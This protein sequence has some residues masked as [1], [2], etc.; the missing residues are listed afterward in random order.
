MPTLNIEGRKVRVGD[1][2]LSLSP[3]EQ[4]ATVEEI[5]ASFSEAPAGASEYVQPAP[6]PGMVMDPETGQ[7][8]DTAQREAVGR[9]IE[10]RT[11]GVGG[12]LMRTG[13]VA[14]DFVRGAADMAT[15]GTADEI[16]AALSGG[17]YEA[18][19]EA[20]RAQDDA[21]GAARF[22]GQMAGGLA[23][24]TMAARTLPAAIGQG[25]LMGGAYGFGS[26]EGG[27]AARA[28]NA[29]YGAAVGGAASG[30][31]Q[32]V[33]NVVGKRAARAAIPTNDELKSAAQR[34][35]Q[36][37]DDAGIIFKPKGIFNLAA[38]ARSD[39]TDFGY[40]PQ[41]QPRIKAVFDEMVNLSRG[42]VTLKGMDTL[43]KMT[44]AAGQST[45]ASER[46]L[47]AKIID[48]IDDFVQNASPDEI[49]T[50]NAKAGQEALGVARDMWRRLKKSQ[51]VDDKVAAADLRAASTG[52]GGNADN[53][54]RQNIRQILTSPKQSRGMTGAEK[55]AAE[56]V[57]R[58]TIPQNAARLAGKLSPEGNG[59]MAALGL[60]G[61]YAAPTLAIPGMIGGAIAKRYAD[62]AT[63]RNVQALSE[64]IRS[65][66]KN[67]TQLALE[68]AKGRGDQK[69][70]ELIQRYLSRADAVRAPSA[71]SAAVLADRIRN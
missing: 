55:K 40:H 9:T 19:L 33:A 35:Y 21:G 1:E 14:D 11:P 65:G 48:R 7:M 70:V 45:D 8:I 66:G 36:A 4:N 61:A 28:E 41:L 56:T 24:P 63:G 22:S 47:A 13:R 10:Q 43:R 23:L 50:G 29:A 38:K 60:G 53:A 25:A 15:F 68:A 37:A 57:V 6:P 34:A 31:V 62:G 64:V 69:T 32:S 71:T 16:S 42:N 26:G 30:A 54:T 2:F 49:L 51:M 59:L 3:D 12:A 46:A 20:E 52:S 5:A 58:G 39:L 67:A 44:A 17:D 27:T 18:N